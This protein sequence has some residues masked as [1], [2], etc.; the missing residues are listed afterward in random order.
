MLCVHVS[1]DGLPQ[2]GRAL[3]QG[4]LERTRNEAGGMQ[5]SEVAGEEGGEELPLAE[6]AGQAAPAIRDR[7]AREV[8]RPARAAMPA[9]ATFAA[10]AMSVALPPK[11]APSASAHQ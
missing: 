4:G 2:A 8:G 1:A 5:L 3:L 11:Q 6:D 10:A 9:A 7:E